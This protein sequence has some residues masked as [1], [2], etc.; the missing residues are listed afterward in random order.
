M[1]IVF[2][3]SGNIATYFATRLHSSGHDIVQVYSRSMG[4]A[5]TLAGCTN[6][7]ATDDLSRIV[8]NA[9]VYILAIKDD[10]L[11]AVAARLVIPGRTVIHCA[12]AVPLEVLHSISEHT[13][14]IWALYSVRKNNLPAGDQIPLV[15]EAG[16]TKARTI[17][18][19]LAK[20]ISQSVL[21]ADFRQRQQLHLSAVFANN[22]SNHLFHI[23]RELCVSNDIP[24]DVLQPIIE[25]TISQ[26]KHLPP[27]QMQTGPAIR[28]D[29]ATMDKH[30][31]LLRH[32]KTWQI[33]YA[34]LSHSIQETHLTTPSRKL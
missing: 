13:A 26:L 25:Q 33:I 17:A 22:F 29:E 16:S 32:N 20:D 6:A 9:D 15:V 21:E 27:D 12:G 14:V 1:R 4:N 23:A 31:E 8:T 2:I 30:L 7:E 10:A 28:N 18:L 24:F 3:G 34:D 5:Q 19:E 11:S